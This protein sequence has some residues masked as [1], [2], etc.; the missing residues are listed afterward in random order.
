MK[1]I[2]IICLVLLCGCSNAAA[3]AK[4]VKNQNIFNDINLND[5]KNI[6][7]VAHPDDETIWGG[8][9]L[10]QEN[11][12]VICLTNG[13]NVVRSKEFH[14]VMEQTHN[15]GIIL[16]YPDKTN[17]K[18]NNWKNVYHDIENDLHYLL[19]NHSFS[20]IVTHNPKGEYGHQHHKMTSAIVT[21]ISRN[22]DITDNLNYF[23]HYYKKSSPLLPMKHL[24]PD[25]VIDQK[26]QLISNYSS[27]NKICNNLRHMFPYENWISYNDWS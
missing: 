25:A 10:L 15:T 3:K 23:G 9:H 14:N 13:N 24:Y 26:K 1:K 16:D 5:F 11:Y 4:Q 12:L 21:S 20:T 22:L 8:I 17:G 18:R 2:I 19:S 7:I 6:M 27:Q